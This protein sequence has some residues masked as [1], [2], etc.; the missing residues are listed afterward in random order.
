MRLGVALVTGAMPLLGARAQPDT[1]RV[2]MLGTGTPNADPDR[3]G[4]SVAIAVNGRAYLVDA[5]P[6][7]IRRAAGAAR[8]GAAALAPERL[9]IVFIT[10]LHSDHTVGLADLMLSPWTLGRTAPLLAFGP[11]GLRS[12][13]EH[14][15][16]AYSAD[17]RNRTTGL[18][19]AN[20]TGWRVIGRDVKP[21][22]V[23]HDSNVTVTA[24]AVPHANW[25]HALGYR[26]A[27]K[28]RIIVVSGDT[29]AS[30]AV[31]QACN[32]CDVLV[33]EAIVAAALDKR[34]ADWQRYH[35]DA[36]TTAVELGEIAV[37]A[38][39]K[40]LVVYHLLPPGASDDDF[41]REIR[42][43]YS[44]PVVIAQDL[45]VY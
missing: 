42:L 23:Y 4:P 32:G 38:H 11:P 12:M 10:H 15:A 19:P 44:G 21:G 45:G 16:A 29:R 17:V 8:K 34:T 13:T 26:F 18:E 1:T 24:F 37:R 39:P 40:L 7:I 9:S 43:H 28:D 5:G 33:H 35:H 20:K 22:V 3:S 41:L 36:H 30:D 2:V 6:G 27:T 14:L 25:E 31:V